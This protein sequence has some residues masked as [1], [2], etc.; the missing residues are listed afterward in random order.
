ME[1]ALTTTLAHEFKR[2]K[3]AFRVYI[4]LHQRL[5]AGGA[6]EDIKIDCYS[7]YIDFV[8]HLY[9]FYL[10]C[11]K[12]DSRYPSKPTKDQIDEAMH[13]EATRLMN[14]R[15]DRILSGEAP[16]WENHIS[17]YEVKIPK[18][19]GQSFRKV[20]NLRSHVN[21][22]RVDFDLGEFYKNFH[23]FL[24][25]MYQDCICLWDVDKSNAPKQDWG[26]IENFTNA[27]LP[28]IK[29]KSWIKKLRLRLFSRYLTNLYLKHN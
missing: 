11:I 13:F 21:S 22:Q 7:A 16:S 5:L 18:E 12:Q 4:I 3:G 1:K 8:A 27:I 6:D 29:T 25:L 20:R 19:F 9:E 17:V 24:F 2:C 10:A 28:N 23:E 26:E 15:R 14:I